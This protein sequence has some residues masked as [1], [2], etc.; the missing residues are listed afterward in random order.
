MSDKP[1][2]PRADALKV[3]KE[4][5][6]QLS[7]WCE[8]RPLEKPWIIVAGSLRRRKELVGDV[9]IL[10]VPQMR[11][12]K[13]AGDWFADEVLVDLI[14]A[15][16]DRLIK[17]GIL[18]KRLTVMGSETWGPKNK[19]AVHVASGIP[20]D[21]FLATK[22]NWYNYLVCRTGSAESNVAIASAAKAMG[23]GWNPY[24]TGFSRPSGLGHEE[25]VITSEREVFEFVGLP[26]K[27]PWER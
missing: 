26:Y 11:M 20:V 13:P 24:G 10:Y 27:E 6:E 17:A 14:S 2:F 9:E 18:K 12:V 1:K 23:W 4:M 22:E 15:R 25:R 16:L 7:P 3:A 8:E 21:L 5:C 19:L